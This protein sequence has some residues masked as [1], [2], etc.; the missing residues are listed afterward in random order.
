MMA[1]DRQGIRRIALVGASDL[2]EIAA[3]SALG[4]EIE[5]VAVVDAQSNQPKLAGLPV[6]R[7]L[8]EVGEIDAVVV[9]DITKPQATY[10]TL[11]KNW[12]DE[13]LFTPAMLRVARDRAR[14]QPQD[15]TL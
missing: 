6:V 2:A 3:L 13:R 10:A 9:T 7:S 5:A 4:S 11:A 14:R 8:D 1:C 12:P 15:E